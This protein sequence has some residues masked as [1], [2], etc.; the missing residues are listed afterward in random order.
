[1]EALAPRLFRQRL[2]EIP[3]RLR[4]TSAVNVIAFR[5]TLQLTHNSKS[6]EAMAVNLALTA[7]L[8]CNLPK[9]RR[10]ICLLL[11]QVRAR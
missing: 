4:G 7:Q 6:D 9:V 2:G 3:G 11:A 8:T 10:R 1:M 5:V